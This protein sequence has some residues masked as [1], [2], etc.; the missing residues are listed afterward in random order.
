MPHHYDDGFKSANAANILWNIT[1]PFTQAPTSTALQVAADTLVETMV[2]KVLK[3]PQPIKDV[4]IAHVL[5]MPFRGSPLVLARGDD[6]FDEE[7]EMMAQMWQGLY[8]APSVLIGQ[9][10]NETRKVGFHLPRPELWNIISV[11]IAQ[12]IS[13]S[14]LNYAQEWFPVQVGARVRVLKAMYNEQ[15]RTGMARERHANDE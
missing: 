13:S 12:G 15:K 3:T 14:V 1:A 10:I 2:R 6:V 7:K 9:Y 11:A 8:Q 5:S 4:A